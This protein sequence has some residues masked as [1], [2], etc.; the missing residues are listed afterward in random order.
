LAAVLALSL[1]RCLRLAP[2][3]DPQQFGIAITVISLGF[4]GPGVG[5]TITSWSTDL[6]E[7]RRRLRVFA[8]RPSTP[9]IGARPFDH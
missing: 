3:L 5:Q 4:I 8:G 7:D 1:I 6:V 9:A 2:T